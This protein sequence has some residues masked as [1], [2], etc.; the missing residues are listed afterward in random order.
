MATPLRA[1]TPAI[2]DH[3]SPTADDVPIVREDHGRGRLSTR[4]VRQRQDYGGELRMSVMSTQGIGP[5]ETILRTVLIPLCVV[6]GAVVVSV[7]FFT[8]I[9]GSLMGGRGILV[10]SLLFFGSVLA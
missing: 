6:A 2:H 4:R 9:V 3:G 10:V 8:G 7:F 5:V 1:V